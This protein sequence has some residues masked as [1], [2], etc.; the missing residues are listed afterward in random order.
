MMTFGGEVGTTITQELWETDGVTWTNRTPA[1]LPAAWPPPLDWQG[2]LFYEPTTRKMILSGS[3]SMA[4]AL[5]DLWAFD[6]TT[7]AFTAAP[8]EPSS[9]SAYPGTF[10]ATA[11][12]GRVMAFQYSSPDRY[13]GHVV[14]WNVA[15]GTITD[16]RPAH[17]PVS[18][19]LTAAAGTRRCVRRAPRAGGVVR[20]RR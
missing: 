18:W 12:G 8:P 2:R 17:V 14:S 19:P 16:L 6:A 1:P 3:P 20:R 13:L 10:A 5:D 9:W 15:A 4:G 7:G 11:G